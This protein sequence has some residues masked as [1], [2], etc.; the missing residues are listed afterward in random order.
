MPAAGRHL[1]ADTQI[2]PYVATPNTVRRGGPM[3][4][5]GAGITS[6]ADRRGVS[7]VPSLRG[8]SAE[9]TGG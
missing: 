7:L 6:I 1:R 9:L 5:P 8:M 2:G 4:P 3:C